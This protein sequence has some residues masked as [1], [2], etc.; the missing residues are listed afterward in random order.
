MRDAVAVGGSV[1]ALALVE[2][3]W[4]RMCFGTREDGSAIA[5]NDPFWDDL[6]AAARGARSRPLVWLE[7]AH[8][9]GDLIHHLA[10]ATSFTRWLDLIWADGSRA[11]IRAFSAS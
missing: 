1:E 4:A 3:L 7:Q 9:Y 6:S 8:L 11:A 5:P 2:A 10:F